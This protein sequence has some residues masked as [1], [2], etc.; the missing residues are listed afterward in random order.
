MQ[1]DVEDQHSKTAEGQ[2]FSGSVVVFDNKIYAFYTAV[3]LVDGAILQRQCMAYSNDG[4]NFTK[5][6]KNPVIESIGIDF[7]DPKVIFHDGYW[8]MVVGGSDGEA[9]DL[10]SHGR[11][12]L[13]EHAR[14]PV[15]HRSG[16]L[17]AL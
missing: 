17:D 3:A 10:K 5:Y 11:I 4:Y 13:L 16:E 1:G 9:C 2:C 15:A 14:R 6:E 7:R 12:Y 8:Q